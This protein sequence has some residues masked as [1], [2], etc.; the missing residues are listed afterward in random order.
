[1]FDRV[2]SNCACPVSV[3]CPL[4][5]VSRCDVGV[6]VG[7]GVDVDVDVDTVVRS[8]A[9]RTASQRRTRMA[10]PDGLHQNA[11]TGDQLDIQL[12]P[13]GRHGH[14]KDTYHKIHN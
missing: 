3:D 14:T 1:M 2:S 4:C 9:V 12:H 10:T 8:G 13:H 11:M 5:D 7:V 6:G